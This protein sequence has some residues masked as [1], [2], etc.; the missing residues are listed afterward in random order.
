M[1]VTVLSINGH[2]SFEFICHRM[3]LR[4]APLYTSGDPVSLAGMSLSLPTH[5]SSPDTENPGTIQAVLCLIR[6]VGA[7]VRGVMPSF[8]TGAV[9]PTG[10]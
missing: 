8:R 2:V 1:S 6:E 4:A 9:R 10:R 3:T 5:F 7:P